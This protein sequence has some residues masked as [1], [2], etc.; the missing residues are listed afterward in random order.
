[1]SPA[2]IHILLNHI[3]LI[4]LFVGTALLSWTYVRSSA[5]I[6]GAA[7]VVIAVSGLLI[8]PVAES[9]EGAEEQIQALIDAPGHVALEAHEERAE[10]AVPAALVAA[11]LAILSLLAIWKKPAAAPAFSAVTLVACLVSLALIGWTAKAG[12]HIRHPEFRSANS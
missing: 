2:Y 6:R 10:A 12:G 4:G 8:V 7:L 11:A 9:G 1:M 5:D 3:P